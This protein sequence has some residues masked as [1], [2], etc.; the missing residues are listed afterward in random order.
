MTS[1]AIY[2]FIGLILALPL[3]YAMAQLAKRYSYAT[4]KDEVDRLYSGIWNGEEEDELNA[5][6][7]V[8][9]IYVNKKAPKKKKYV[10][11]QIDSLNKQKFYSSTLVDEK[12]KLL[13][14]SQPDI[15][16]HD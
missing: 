5:W 10:L 12:G 13:N 14:Y 3:S 4:Y 15:M 2:E 11:T 9:S 6:L 7:K 16:D 1:F 8:Y